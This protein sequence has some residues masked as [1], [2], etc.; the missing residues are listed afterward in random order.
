MIKSV[1][2]FAVPTMV[3]SCLNLFVAEE[4][5]SLGPW[6]LVCALVPSLEGLNASSVCLS[7]IFFGGGW[8]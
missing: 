7:T 8:I 4:N 1:V 3:P 6:G 5:V 2:P